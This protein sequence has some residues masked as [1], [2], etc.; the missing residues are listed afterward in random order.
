[1]IRPLGGVVT[2]KY[3]VVRAWRY[4]NP[5]D[6][7]ATEYAVGDPYDGPTDKNPHLLDPGGPDGVGP[8]IAEKPAAS[9]TDTKEK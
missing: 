1:M 6:G 3:E 8:L 2:A 9:K 7:T 4:V 5:Q